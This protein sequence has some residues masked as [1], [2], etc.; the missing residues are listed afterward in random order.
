MPQSTPL[1]VVFP[2][3]ISVGAKSRICSGRDPICLG[4]SQSPAWMYDVSRKSKDHF[5]NPCCK[6][7]C[8]KNT[9]SKHL[10]LINN[11]MVHTF[12]CCK[13]YTFCQNRAFFLFHDFM[14]TTRDDGKSKSLQLGNSILGIVT[15]IQGGN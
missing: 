5:L 3:L 2:N 7:R 12:R 4:I 8:T 14:A 6:K 10:N 15:L 11:F 9:T 1:L 13:N